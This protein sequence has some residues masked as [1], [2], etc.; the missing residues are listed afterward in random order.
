MAALIDGSMRTVRR[1]STELRPGLL[2]DLGLAAAIEWQVGEFAE[3]T[4]IRCDLHLSEEGVRLESDVATALFRILQEAL[5]NVAR[6]AEADE[7]HVE[8]AVDPGEVVLRVADDGR[9]ITESEISSSHALGLLGMRERGRTLGG[10]V[11]FEGV[12]GQGTVV[13]ASIP[14]RVA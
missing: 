7:V 4:G 2:D 3:R 11:R 1:V 8:L 10:E 6:H 9:G 12:A 5:T 13:T 14:R